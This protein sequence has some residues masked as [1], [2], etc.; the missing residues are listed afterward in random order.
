MSYLHGSKVW[1][2]VVLVGLVVLAG[3]AGSGES[4]D[5]KPDSSAAEKP[6]QGQPDNSAISGDP[7]QVVD[8]YLEGARNGDDKQVNSLLTPIARAEMA[9]RNFH[10]APPAS[11]TTRFE[12][13]EVSRPSDQVAYVPC[14]LIDQ[15]G[16]NAKPKVSNLVWALRMTKEGWRIGGMAIK[17]TKDDNPILLDF[18]KPDEIVKMRETVKRKAAQQNA[19]PSAGQPVRTALPPNQSISR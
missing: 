1:I 18:E 6:A 17:V 13:G 11:D 4:G 14:R 15:K 10:V 12:L 3:C 9:K 19:G 8:A 16:D 7:L 5:K 2:G